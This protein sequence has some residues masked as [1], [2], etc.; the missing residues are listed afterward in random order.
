[1]KTLT[2]I[3]WVIIGVYVLIAIMLVLELGKP[4]DA[5]GRGLTS[6][7]LMVALMLLGLLVIFNLIPFKWSR[8]VALFIGFSPIIVFFIYRVLN[9]IQHHR[10]ERARKDVSIYFEDGKMKD[11][12]EA[13]AHNRE[14]E[15]K[16]FLEDPE[17]DLNQLGHNGHTMLEVATH[18][19]SQ[20]Y[21]ASPIQIVEMLLKKGADPNLYGS[22]REPVLP[23]IASSGSVPLFEILLQH[24]ADPNAVGS[25]SLPV[26]FVLL[27]G[28]VHLDEK[29]HLLLDYGADPN[30]KWAKKDWRYNFS[31]LIYAIYHNHWK[32][33]TLLIQN[34]ADLEHVAPKRR[35]FLGIL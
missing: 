25:D 3:N 12:A 21:L 11:L 14:E 26:I 22:G 4:L 27:Q 33:C 6:G 24:G 1:M 32:T 34:G 35:L 15:V 19:A 16:A 30:V 23:Q 10:W 13:I 31:P 9:D 17:I 18:Y 29:M 8:I 5:M 7:F 2:L 20:Y 28:S